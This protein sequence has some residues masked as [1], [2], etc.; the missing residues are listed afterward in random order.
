MVQNDTLTLTQNEN[1]TTLNT[2]TNGHPSVKSN[3]ANSNNNNNIQSEMENNNSGKQQ[4]QPTALT[5]DQVYTLGQVIGKGPFSLIRTAVHKATNNSFAVK[6]IDVAKFTSTPGLSADDLK[7]EAKICSLLKHP[8]IIELLEVYTIGTCLYM[9]FELMEGKDLLSEIIK[10]VNANYVYS[11]AVAAHYLRQIFQALNYAHENKVVHRDVHP[12]CLLFHTKDNGSSVKLGG[13]GTAVDLSELE[14]KEVAKKAASENSDLAD[15]KAENGDENGKENDKETPEDPQTSDDLN[16]SIPTDKYFCSPEYFQDCKPATKDDSWSVG[17]LTYLLVF[18][19]TPF[20]CNYD[21][22]NLENQIIN[23]NVEDDILLLGT[24]VKQNHQTA[25]D[26]S[27]NNTVMANQ[28]VA[29]SSDV[30]DLCKDFIKKL[31]CR[32]YSER[33]SVREALEHPWMTD[34]IGFG[35]CLK[36]NFQKNF[37]QLFRKFFQKA[38]PHEPPKT[39]PLR[40]SPQHQTLLRPQKTQRQNHA[41][42]RTT[43]PRHQQH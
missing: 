36:T 1:T 34:I 20:H 5:F 25:I 35:G 8:N 23:Y 2:T 31:L 12:A 10:R 3:N 32:K 15:L 13:F 21:I 33:M 27:E 22:S 7:R 43:R 24:S 39:P 14:A 37:F 17:I 19:R 11:E 6:I 18:G 30:S 41:L 40:S 9:V 29:L 26:N 28:N 42:S 38:S 4:Q 16:N